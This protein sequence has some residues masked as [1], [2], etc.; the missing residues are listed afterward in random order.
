MKTVAAD[1]LTAQGK[2]TKISPRVRLIMYKEYPGEIIDY[3]TN[4]VN[5]RGN[6]TNFFSVGDIVVLP[7]VD[8]TEEFTIISVGAYADGKTL[9]LKSGGSSW[10]SP[11]ASSDYV[12]L[13]QDLSD[14]ILHK[15]IGD[16]KIEVEGETLNLLSNDSVTVKFDDG[17]DYLFNESDK[18]GI[19]Y[20]GVI[21]DSV[22]SVGSFRIYATVCG[23]YPDD[24]FNGLY[25]EVIGDGGK[26]FIYPIIDHDSVEKY[27]EVW[28]DTSP[29]A[30]G[31]VAGDTLNIIYKNKFYV[32]IYIGYKEAITDGS[33]LNDI[34]FFGGFALSKDIT[35]D[36]DRKILSVRFSGFMR[37]L[38]NTYAYEAARESGAL[39][40]IK[41]VKAIDYSQSEADH[42]LWGIRDLKYNYPG[43]ELVTGISINE[44]EQTINVGLKRLEFKRP[45]TFKYDGGGWTVK[46]EEKYDDPNGTRIY[47]VDKDNN[48]IYCD[49]KP[50]EYP[51]HD[52]EEFINIVVDE[53]TKG[54]FVKNKGPAIIA[55][56]D[57]EEEVLKTKFTK[58]AYGD[59]WVANL[60]DSTDDEPEITLLDG[61]SAPQFVVFGHYEK[62]ESLE[63]VGIDS[64]EVISS[65]TWEY[66]QGY[67]SSNWLELTVT[68][69]TNQLNQDGRVYFYPPIDWTER[70]KA[71][72]SLE[73]AR[74][75]IR[76]IIEEGDPVTICEKV[77][78]HTTVKSKKGDKITVSADITKLQPKSISDE[79]IIKHDSNGDP[80][81]GVWNYSKRVK[82]L[83]DDLLTC[84]G[85]VNNTAIDE[86]KI[87]TISSQINLWGRPPD[88]SEDGLCRAMI[89]AGDR[90]WLGID[91]KIYYVT[92]EGDYVY[93]GTLGPHYDIVFMAYDSDISDKIWGIAIRRPIPYH[94]KDPVDFHEVMHPTM[95]TCSN[96]S[97]GIPILFKTVTSGAI[98]N[99]YDCR[100]YFRT[101]GKFWQTDPSTIY[102]NLMG[103]FTGKTFYG[104]NVCIPL[105][106]IFCIRLNTTASVSDEGRDTEMDVSI[107]WQKFLTISCD[108]TLPENLK[109]GYYAVYI[110]QPSVD[111]DE[112]RFR[113]TFGQA[114]NAVFHPGLNTLIV[115]CYGNEGYTL[116]SW[117]IGGSRDLIATFE[118]SYDFAGTSRIQQVRPNVT[119]MRLGKYDPNYKEILF[120]YVW[121]DE[122]NE[123]TVGA[124]SGYGYPD[125]VYAFQIGVLEMFVP[126]KLDHGYMI[127]AIWFYDDSEA[128]W[129]DVTTELNNLSSGTVTVEDDDYLYFASDH[130]FAYMKLNYTVAP[131]IPTET[132]EISDGNGNWRDITDFVTRTI[133][134]PN[135]FYE[136]PI[137]HSSDDSNPPIWWMRDDEV[138]MGVA[139]KYLLRVKFVFAS[140]SVT[141]QS[142]RH[143]RK[144][145]WLSYDG[146]F[147][148]AKVGPSTNDLIIIDMVYN[149]NDD[150]VYGCMLCRKDMEYYVFTY[151]CANGRADIATLPNFTQAGFDEAK[152]LK[153][154]QYNPV[155]NNIYCVECDVKNEKATARLLRI[156][157]GDTPLVVAMND[158]KTKE[159]ECPVQSLAIH[160]TDGIIAGIAG[161]E[162]GYLWLYYNEFYIRVMRAAYG[163]SNVKEI[164]SKLLQLQNMIMY[165]NSDRQLYIKKRDQTSNYQS[166]GTYDLGNKKLISVGDSSLYSHICDGVKINWGAIDLDADGTEEKGDI[167]INKKILEINNEFINDSHTARLVADILY[168]FF[169]R[170]RQR[171]DIKAIPLM[172][173]DLWDVV[174]LTSSNKYHNLS[175]S[176][177]WNIIMTNLSLNRVMME[178]K[179]LERM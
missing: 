4:Y 122:K 152:Q 41:G 110:A 46:S 36:D 164:M 87:E 3:Y 108:L 22:G 112:F 5:V 114:F 168:A 157:G 176:A 25:A 29:E 1:F 76:F 129:T 28:S 2:H 165:I 11:A 90:L 178:I 124:Q 35:K 148:W 179:L 62:F 109:L 138:N 127:T 9:L 136:F 103:R 82:D 102:W 121:W 151:N 78:L 174:K 96:A 70:Y 173:H 111:L 149:P 79:I 83:F 74:Y 160:Q 45:N 130:K 101:G 161:P 17:D 125:G 77:I 117:A 100:F 63:F 177:Y 95:F 40:M 150:Y 137:M 68:D 89:W 32:A 128:D 120:A 105:K 72:S 163:E 123:W 19:F 30:N 131:E 154:F 146:F 171:V 167:A 92:I 169:G 84:A 23:D 81:I 27:I 8:F 156:S 119:A 155:D 145:V 99:P 52:V 86:T 65:G 158:I 37:E 75:Y 24:T 73:H 14:R 10:N 38:E 134:P 141:V 51:I 66:S 53:K 118:N 133:D 48:K 13:K 104:E 94:S 47:L 64:D 142:M 55:L 54:V 139:D 172:Q 39:V 31:C 56:D 97:S 116:R 85:Y 21:S 16:F 60:T 132:W 33:A 71:G 20:Q 166:G 18:T 140:D 6:A 49:F 159:W 115:L 113:S 7:C 91:E 26:R 42:V 67:G 135:V 147:W 144:A 61:S 126:N 170:Y 88:I 15:G 143:L 93:V 106:S 43:D 153:S 175:R 69:G 98:H 107:L 58:I 80:T 12:L 50:G 59:D 34:R 57:G 162:S 44:I